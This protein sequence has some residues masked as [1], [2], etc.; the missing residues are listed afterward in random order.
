MNIQ[1]LLYPLTVHGFLCCFQS[2]LLVNKLAPMHLC[3]C[4]CGIHTGVQTLLYVY[5]TLFSHNT[6]LTQLLKRWTLKLEEFCVRQVQGNWLSWQVWWQRN[7]HTLKQWCHFL[8]AIS[9]IIAAGRQAAP[10]PG[11]Y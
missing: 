7:L 6:K 5:L 10:K 9:I 8:C 3:K 1:Q 2:L 4:F 11:F